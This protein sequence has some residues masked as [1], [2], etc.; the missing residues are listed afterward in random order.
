MTKQVS[1]IVA[2]RNSERFLAE[3]LES[4][5]CSRQLVHEI[6]IVDGGST[7]KTIEIAHEFALT[8]IVPQSGVGIA[9]AYNT[10]IAEADCPIIAFNSSDDLWSTNKLQVQLDFLAAN[11]HIDL[12]VGKAEFFLEESD[13]APSCF[14]KELLQAPRVAYIMETLL[15]KKSVFQLVGTFDEQL[16][17]AEDVDWY[18]RVRESNVHYAAVEEVILRKRVHGENSSNAVSN[19]D[20]LLQALFRSTRRK[21][22]NRDTD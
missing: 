9:G 20:Y 17:T 13:T 11:P 19:N 7:D 16:R 3:C 21:R 18:C 5:L 10:G 12:V 2:T 4:I 14:R 1:V 8:K 15:V 6:L 22:Q